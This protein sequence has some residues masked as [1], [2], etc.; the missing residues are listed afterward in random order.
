MTT[1][2]SAIDKACTKARKTLALLFRQWNGFIPMGMHE[3][4]R[5]SFHKY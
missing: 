2:S 3:S 5:V 1:I 4:H